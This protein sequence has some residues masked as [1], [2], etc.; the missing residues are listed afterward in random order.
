MMFNIKILNF[1]LLIHIETWFNFQKQLSSS[2]KGQIEVSLQICDEDN[3]TTAQHHNG[4]STN[5]FEDA[6]NDDPTQKHRSSTKSLKNRDETD[7]MALNY[8]EGST[9]RES[10]GNGINNGNTS[11]NGES[12]T[13]NR[14]E[15]LPMRR[16]SRW[17]LGEVK[18]K[19]KGKDKQM[20]MKTNTFLKFNILRMRCSIKVKE[21][22]ENI[23]GENF[24]F[25]TKR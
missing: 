3:D 17:S 22:F 15:S 18:K 8:P 6:P 4:K 24:L 16:S 14:T 1:F 21:E 2:S 25:L 10:Y 11:V 20:Q 13:L 12:L 23:A 7:I 19:I 5:P 9:N